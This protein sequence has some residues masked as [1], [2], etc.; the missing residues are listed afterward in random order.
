MTEQFSYWADFCSI[1]EYDKLWVSTKR[2]DGPNPELNDVVQ[3]WDHEGN[4]A[5][6]V[7]VSDTM[8]ESIVVYIVEF[9]GERW[10]D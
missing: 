9:N 3:L 5:I 1:D 6:G 7:V 8:P 4:K 10:H 2:V